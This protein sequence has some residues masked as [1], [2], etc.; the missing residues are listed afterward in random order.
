[1]LLK[2]IR[3]DYRP[4]AQGSER[5]NFAANLDRVGIA[6]YRG[7]PAAENVSGSVSGDL[8]RGELRLN[9]EDFAL[10]LDQFFAK[11][12]RYHQAQARLAWHWDEQGVTLASPYLRLTGD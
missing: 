11:P 12:W 4:G 9:T 8:N 10:H 3:L 7:V 6:A 5:L 1:G 2:N